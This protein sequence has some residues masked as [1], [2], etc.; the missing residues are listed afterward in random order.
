[1]TTTK[2]IQ[3]LYQRIGSAWNSVQIQTQLWPATDSLTAENGC[4]LTV[5]NYQQCLLKNKYILE[6][7][8]EKKKQTS[9]FVSSLK[10]SRNEY[11]VTDN[12]EITGA[13]FEEKELISAKTSKTYNILIAKTSKN[14]S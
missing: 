12:S 4:L 11:I 2:K 1:M 10:P 3:E 6:G 7:Q 9:S 5:W 13:L 14:T 8:I